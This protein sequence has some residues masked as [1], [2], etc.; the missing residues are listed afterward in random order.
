MKYEIEIDTTDL[1]G[2]V[3]TEDYEMI[4]EDIVRLQTFE[5]L[6][7]YQTEDLKDNLKWRDAMAIL[8][9]YYLPYAE[10]ES[11]VHPEKSSGI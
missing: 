8:L 2:E 11:I 10:A 5:S 3:L 9:Y 1:I 6:E 7:L 4:C